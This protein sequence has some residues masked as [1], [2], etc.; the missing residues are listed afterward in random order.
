[1]INN[2]PKKLLICIVIICILF[3]SVI[4]AY[5]HEA[6]LDIEYDECELTFKDNGSTADTGED[7]IWYYLNSRDISNYVRHLDDKTQTIRY[8][9]ADSAKDDNTY[10]WTTDIKEILGI[11][12]EEAEQ[13]AENIKQ[14]Y[15]ASMKKWNNVYYYSYDANGNRVANKVI[16]I[17]E[18]TEENHNL[19]IYPVNYH[20]Q[21]ADDTESI[22][23]VTYV[24]CVGG[25]FFSHV[26]EELEINPIHYHCSDW[27]ME[28]NVT[29]FFAHGKVASEE[30]KIYEPQIDQMDANHNLDKVGMHEMGHVLGLMD[31]DV[32]CHTSNKQG[33]DVN[34]H[35]ELLMGYSESG[36]PTS[37]SYQDIAGVSITRGF[38]TD[39]DH[40]WML[41]TNDD[42]TQDV[43]CAQCNGVRKDITLTNGT[44]EGKSVNIYKSCVHYGGTNEEMLLVATDGKRN[45][46]KCQYCRYIE[47]KDLSTYIAAPTCS[48]ITITKEMSGKSTYQRLVVSR[49][50]VY[51][52]NSS[53]INNF[54]FK[55]YDDNL[56]Y[57][58]YSFNGNESGDYFNVYLNEG[59]Y[60]LKISNNASGT[61]TYT[62]SIKPTVNTHSY[63][64]WRTYSTTHHIECCE[65][66]G[67]TGT[68]TSLHVVKS[69]DVSLGIGHCMHCGAKVMLNDDIVETPWLSVPK[70]TVNGSYILPNGIIVLVDADIEA[71]ENGTLVFCD[72][73]KLPVTQ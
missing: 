13:M 49:S 48:Q 23:D 5:A 39:D 17:M 8:Y 16:N 36:D 59:T 24:A 29:H 10:T 30:G 71:Y 68:R 37:A 53:S 58:G 57:M 19:T 67:L 64:D 60:Y 11:A 2:Q 51:K 43:I 54:T 45:F 34:H 6:L 15:V 38:H 69:S 65:Y 42:G 7:E 32:E 31:V 28:V 61:A 50:G 3:G 22:F 18:G 72:K 46:F 21:Y 33:Y 14:A 35:N 4:S 44:Y 41:R 27:Y 62:F 20:K 47:T 55:L 26:V 63:T 1:M 70:V 40:V 73:D 66:C 52:F 56:N 12:Q 25:R 9:F